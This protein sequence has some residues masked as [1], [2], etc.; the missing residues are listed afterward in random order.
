MINSTIESFCCK[1]DQNWCH[2]DSN[3]LR[4]SNPKIV[5]KWFI[6]YKHVN[7]RIG[8]RKEKT[9][10]KLMSKQE[11]KNKI[12]ETY[13]VRTHTVYL[14]CIVEDFV[15]SIS[16][17]FV[18]ICLIII[19]PFTIL[20]FSGGKILCFSFLFFFVKILS[21]D[22]AAEN[23]RNINDSIDFFSFFQIN[24]SSFG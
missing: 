2:C 24:F 16:N 3:F 9:A 8:T 17:K 20:S 21:I 11:K 7:Q 10:P 22:F 19:T 15:H 4:W 6:W 1:S 5:H 13:W 23:Y 14:I 18:H 12:N